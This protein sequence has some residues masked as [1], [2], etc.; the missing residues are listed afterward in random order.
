MLG[1][2]FY[3]WN[4]LDFG[5]TK[6]NFGGKYPQKNSTF[7]LLITRT[8][9]TMP[10]ASGKQ[11]RKI[12]KNFIDG[13]AG[14]SDN[15][16]DNDTDKETDNDTDSFVAEDTG[17][18]TD[19][20]KD[21]DDG[22]DEK[23]SVDLGDS[24]DDD[25]WTAVTEAKP[26]K[27]KEKASEEKPK[28]S[29]E[30]P[31]A[32]KV[33]SQQAKA[34]ASEEKSKAKKVKSPRKLSQQAKAKPPPT[35]EV[36]SEP[37][38]P[39]KPRVP[40]APPKAKRTK[41]TAKP[42]AFAETPVEGRTMTCDQQ[43]KE[44]QRFIDNATEDAQRTVANAITDQASGRKVRG[45]ATLGGN[46]D[47]VVTDD[48]LDFCKEFVDSF[49]RKPHTVDAFFNAKRALE[50]EGYTVAASITGAPSKRSKYQ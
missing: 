23:G 13:E 25:D 31:K 2:Q 32:K 26:V 29:E 36:Q 11:D 40:E 5:I 22:Q 10:P 15:D 45:Y 19:D 37:D 41:A 35:I 46:P 3:S 6:N 7:H 33:K 4:F 39:E 14:C 49:N 16:T 34:K 42:K 20:E 43:R 28:A 18:D 50:E 24:T 21:D 38:E 47:K 1:A 27:P 17:D 44:L 9:S 48:A 8:R 30:K 12:G